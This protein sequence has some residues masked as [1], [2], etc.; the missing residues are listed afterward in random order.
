MQD[1]CFIGKTVKRGSCKLC[2]EEADLCNSHYLGR[3]MYSLI[4][5]LGDRII[6]LSPSR[7]MPTDMQITDYLVCS[8][9]E[10][11]FSNRGEKYATSLVNRGGSFMPLDLME[12]CGT[13]RT[14]GAESLYRARD[15]G[16]DAAT[17]GYYALSV[18][19]R[20]THVWPAFRGTTV[21]GL[22]LGI[23]GE[24]IRAF[25]DGAEVSRR[26]SSSR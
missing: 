4:R 18:V 1:N 10:Q 19:W 12:K 26:T 7:I 14:Q 23:H 15:L 5:K 17:L 6:M 13:M 22:Q 21:G 25:L 20:G 8:T 11:K 9:C 16:L 24:P 3:R 2:L